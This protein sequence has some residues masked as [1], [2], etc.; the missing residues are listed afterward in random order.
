ML[1]NTTNIAEIQSNLGLTDAQITKAELLYLCRI[2]C[3]QAKKP[4]DRSGRAKEQL[5]K[6]TRYPRIKGEGS[7]G[8]LGSVYG[9]RPDFVIMVTARRIGIIGD[10]KWIASRDRFRGKQLKRLKKIPRKYKRIV[11]LDEKACKC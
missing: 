10:F 4:G 11:K 2:V 5:A 7:L 8:R 9:A 3:A 6:Q 1:S